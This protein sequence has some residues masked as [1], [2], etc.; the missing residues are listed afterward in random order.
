MIIMIIFWVGCHD[1]GQWLYQRWVGYREEDCKMPP[2]KKAILLVK[3][4]PGVLAGEPHQ[5]E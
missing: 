2:A 5:L 4:I 3:I 1:D